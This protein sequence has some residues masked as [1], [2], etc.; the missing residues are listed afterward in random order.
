MVEKSDCT[1][2]GCSIAPTSKPLFIDTE[3]DPGSWEEA[4]KYNPNIKVIEYE[5]E[6]ND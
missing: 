4:L 3:S 6:K 1:T 5:G 2:N